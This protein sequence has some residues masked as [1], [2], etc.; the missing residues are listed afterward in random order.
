[1]ATQLFKNFPTI[2]Y[3]LN[4]GRIIHIKDFFRK[5][6]IELQKVNTLV[7]YEYYELQEGERPD[8]VASKLY[9]D[10]D[11]HWVLFLVNEID[12]YYDWYM[13]V[14]TFNNYLD[15]KYE[16]VYLT[17][18]A[19]T[20]IVGPH[21]TDNQGNF[22]SD[23]KFLL[24]E[25]VTQGDVKGHVLQVDATKSQLRVTAGDWREDSVVSGSLKSMTVQGVVEPRDSI[26]HYVNANGIKSTTPQAG[27]SSV[28]I[29]KHEYELNE[30]KRK[31]KIIKPQYVR[32][33]VTQYEQLL[34]V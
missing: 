15:N 33:V 22:V 23:N 16:G 13:D 24:G 25:V 21:N 4:D 34:Q 26:S 28:S 3:K 17:A 31:I 2:Q 18:A 12:N 8:I 29:W 30:D 7:D 6:K 1:M 11:L 14:E 5:G 10:S 27:F 19:S 9:G 32:T 20:D